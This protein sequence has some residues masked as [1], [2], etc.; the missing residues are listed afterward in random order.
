MQLFVAP[1]LLVEETLATAVPKNV[2]GL[3]VPV[4]SA[5]HLA[6]IALETFRPKDRLRLEIFLASDGFDRSRFESVVAKFKL[7]RNW[8]RFLAMLEE[9]E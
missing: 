2:D 3:P 9:T 5:E 6:A 7:E 4:F 8:T 1:T